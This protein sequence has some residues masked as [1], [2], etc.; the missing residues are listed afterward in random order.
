[1]DEAP[2]RDTETVFDFGQT[3]APLPAAKFIFHS[4]APLDPEATQLIETGEEVITFDTSAPNVRAAVYQAPPVTV[5]PVQAPPVQDVP[6]LA[7]LSIPPIPQPDYVFEFQ[8]NTEAP[9]NL[10]AAARQMERQPLLPQHTEPQDTEL[11][12]REEVSSPLPEFAAAYFHQML[13]QFEVLPV[14]SDD[15]AQCLNPN[16]QAVAAIRRLDAKAA[17]QT[18]TWAD[19]DQM[20]LALLSVLPARLLA[21]HGE[22]LHARYRETLGREFSDI[23]TFSDIQ[24]EEQKPPEAL[25]AELWTLLIE[26]QQSRRLLPELVYQ[27]TQLT[28]TCVYWIAGLAAFGIAVGGIGTSLFEPLPPEL[29]PVLLLGATLLGG[30]MGG[31]TGLLIKA[32]QMR[33]RVTPENLLEGQMSAEFP[34]AQPVQGAIFAGVLF[35]LYE[36]F[37]GRPILSSLPAEAG[38]FLLCGFAA[39]LLPDLRGR[40]AS[41]RSSAPKKSA[42]RKPAKV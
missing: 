41:R 9:A 39:G 15:P 34:Y 25:R 24:T 23:K 32:Q 20:E 31:F 22:M 6:V 7:P 8:P 18:L 17:A 29:L 16:P 28:R 3:P 2:E 33:P 12:Q 35:F 13:T 40:L 11:Q 26:V 36:A 30:A 19:L 37:L 10:G 42:A 27:R 14:T 4:S 21:P 38:R 1:M 5:V